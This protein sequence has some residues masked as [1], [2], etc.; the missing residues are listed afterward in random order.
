MKLF[1]QNLIKCLLVLED[2]V[3]QKYAINKT[4]NTD[5]MMGHWNHR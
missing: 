1:Y 5:F 4:H 2:L 3:F